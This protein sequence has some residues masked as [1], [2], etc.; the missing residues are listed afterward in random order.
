VLH[1]SI[2]NGYGDYGSEADKL[3]SG[4][5]NM[6]NLIELTTPPELLGI[7]NGL[8]QYEPIFHHPEFGTTRQDFENMTDAAFWE[9]GASGRRYS[10]DYTL[11]EVVKRYEDPKYRGIH[12]P[13]ENTWQT[14][15]FHC[16]EIAR[17]N[18]LLTYTLIQ[19]DLVTRRSTLWRH[20]SS[21]WKILYHQGTIVQDT[22]TPAV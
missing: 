17:D 7:L 11:A 18:Y 13:P 20:T 5:E 4:D 22:D 9:V 3:E 8:I 2:P 1:F 6:E 16:L 19:G 15:D 14:K 12:S 10:R 21:G